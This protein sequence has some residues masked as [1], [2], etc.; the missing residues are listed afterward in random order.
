VNRLFIFRRLVGATAFTCF[1]VVCLPQHLVLGAEAYSILSPGT[2]GGGSTAHGISSTGVVTGTSGE[3]P[4]QHAFIY[5]NGTITDLGT[6]HG[7]DGSKFLISAG[8]AVNAS[9]QAV[10]ESIPSYNQYPGHAFLY[11]SG[12]MTD[13]G[14]LGGTGSYANA[15]NNVGQVVGSAQV[16]GD[17]AYHAFLYANGQMT[18]LGTLGGTRSEARAI[19]DS[20]QI[21]GSADITG[22]TATH[23]YI[24]SNGTMKDLG[25]SGTVQGINAS[26]QITGFTEDAENIYHAFLYSDGTLTMMTAPGAAYTFGYGINDSGQIV[27]ETLLSDNST[28]HALLFSNGAVTDLNTLIDPTSGWTLNSATGINDAGQIVGYGT[29]NGQTQAFLLTPISSTPTTSTPEPTTL[30]P[31][32]AAIPLLLKTRRK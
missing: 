20:G 7:S 31:L 4:D 25:F 16:A 18:D 1:G 14:T 9:G 12:Q 15:I 21:A 26:G 17:R 11:S 30:L 24:Y 6:L 29:L 28:F 19:N 2:L 5:S 3:S 13:L 8:Y 10:G 23:T 32:L 22:D 27:G